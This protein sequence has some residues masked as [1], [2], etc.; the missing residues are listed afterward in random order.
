MVTKLDLSTVQVGPA[1]FSRDRLFR[2]SLERIWDRDR[3]RVAFI[4]LN[5]S[6]ADEVRIDNTISRCARFAHDWGYGSFL[7]LNLFAFRTVSPSVLKAAHLWMD[8]LD[9]TGGKANNDAIA[10]GVGSTQ[11][12]ICAWGAHGRFLGRADQVLSGLAAAGQGDK[13]YHLGLNNDG[14]PKHPLYLP[15]DTEPEPWQ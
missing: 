10:E 2:Y 4:G 14:S 15:A 3:P 7:M 13:L 8:D 9:V 1:S 12:T 6:T 5:P 11:M